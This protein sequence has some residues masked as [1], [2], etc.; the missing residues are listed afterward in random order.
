MLGGYSGAHRIVAPYARVVSEAAIRSP[1][2]RRIEADLHP[3]LLH[4]R[5]AH[6]VYVVVRVVIVYIARGVVG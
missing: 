4:R 6:V 3:V 1:A 2:L 5:L